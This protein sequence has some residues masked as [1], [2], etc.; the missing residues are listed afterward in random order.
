[1]NRADA[2]KLLE[3]L[4]KKWTAHD[5]PNGS[6]VVAKG[7]DEHSCMVF[8]SAFIKKHEDYY[9]VFPEHHEAQIFHEDEYDVA[10]YM[11]VR[12]EMRRVLP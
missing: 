3:T 7:I 1:M 8:D 10:Q 12:H 9:F 5:Y 11:V 2:R 4:D 6:I